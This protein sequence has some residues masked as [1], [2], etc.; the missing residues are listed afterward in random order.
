MTVPFPKLDLVEALAGAIAELEAALR[1]EQA[2]HG[3][4]EWPETQLQG[5][6]AEALARE[7]EIEREVHYPSASGRKRSARA[8]CDFVLRRR[9]DDADP[10]ADALWLELK[11]A[12][13]RTTGGRVDPRYG[14][15]WR[16][17][18]I[19]DLKKLAGDPRI[20]DAAIALVAFTEDEAQLAR[21]LDGFERLLIRRDVI[22]GFRQVRTL[23]IVERI[24]HRVCGVAVWPTV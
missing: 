17:H 1:L 21:D 23:P 11:V 24:G 13:Q 5:A 2:V 22:A 7:H 18:L 16:R 14:E 10:I 9:G 6:L 19:A 20:R 12:R 15:Q 8:R 4:D 3:I